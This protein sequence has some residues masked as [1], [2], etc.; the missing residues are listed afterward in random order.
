MEDKDRFIELIRA[1]PLVSVDLV[2]V[3]DGREPLPIGEALD[4]EAERAAAGWE[5]CWRYRRN[6]YCRRC[7]NCTW[8]N[9]R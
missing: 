7:K 9:R 6:Y 1:L 3:R 2:L 8:N 4:A 5:W